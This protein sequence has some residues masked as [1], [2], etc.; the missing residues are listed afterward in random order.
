LGVPEAQ[1]DNLFKMFQRFHP[2]T[3]CGSGLGLYM[4]NKSAD[5]LHGNI[6]YEACS[7]GSVFKLELPLGE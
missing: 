5:I 6:S 2:R 1:R 4:M 7:D 3:S